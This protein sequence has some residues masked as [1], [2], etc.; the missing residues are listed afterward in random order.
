[1]K[2]NL[3]LMLSAALITVS[4][5]KKD[6]KNDPIIDPTVDVPACLTTK[7]T[8]KYFGG[9]SVLNFTYDNSGRVILEK[10]PVDGFETSYTYTNN[11]IVKV[12]KEPNS[13]T[14]THT[15]N[16]DAS[17]KVI[18]ATATD[19]KA[20]YTYN[21]DNYLIEIKETYTLPNK[22]II[23]DKKFSYTDGNLTSI[24]S[25][26]ETATLTYGTALAKANF[27]SPVESVF[28]EELTGPL[29]KYFG[30]TSKNLITKISYS[31]SATYQTWSYESD[32]K[33]NITKVTGVSV[34]A[35]PNLAFTATAAYTCK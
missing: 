16:L 26:D 33:Q 30:K 19:Y 24:K 14:F 8:F 9:E 3:I 12:A 20:E 34:P 6:K 18:T 2:K 22:T 11:Q 25:D 17:G 35:D 10:T 4:S 28:A 13:Q 1:M 31:D 32:N 29:R 7:T 23:E 21:S 5:C 15:Y 27:L